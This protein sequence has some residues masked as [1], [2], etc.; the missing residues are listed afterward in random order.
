MTD[1]KPSKLKWI[2]L[3]VAVLL[4]ASATLCVFSEGGQKAIAAFRLIQAGGNAP[5]AAEIARNTTCAVAV[6]V[7]T[8]AIWNLERDYRE[9][10]PDPSVLP[11]T[12]VMCTVR[13]HDTPPSCEDVAAIYFQATGNSPFVVIVGGGAAATDGYV[14]REMFEVDGGP[15]PPMD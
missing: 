3:G 11:P 1:K 6:A 9:A 13:V 7:E 8:K 10:H 14:C 12:T 15:P 2:L 4:V 5:G